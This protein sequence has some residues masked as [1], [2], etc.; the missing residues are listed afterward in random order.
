MKKE[1]RKT[2]ATELLNASLSILEKHSS[3]ATRKVQK[4][5]KESTKKLSKKFLKAINAIEKK[6]IAANGAAVVRTPKKKARPKR[7]AKVK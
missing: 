1:E 5:L 7:A 3:K 2:L 6:T 4:Q